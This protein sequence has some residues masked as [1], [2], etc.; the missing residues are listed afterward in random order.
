MACPKLQHLDL[1]QCHGPALS[2]APIRNC[3]DLRVIILPETW[4]PKT[5]DLEPI[6]NLPR[7]ERVGEVPWVDFFKAYDQARSAAGRQGP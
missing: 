6:R 2:L 1:R 4:E 7:L 3:P 5:K